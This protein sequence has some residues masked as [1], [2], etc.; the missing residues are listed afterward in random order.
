VV[1]G[2]NFKN[3]KD[4]GDPVE[5][6]TVYEGQGADELMLLDVSAPMKDA[7]LPWMLLAGWRL[8]SRFPLGWVEASGVWMILGRFS[9]PE[10]QRSVSTLPQCKTPSCCSLRATLL[11][12]SGLSLQLM[13]LLPPQHTQMQWT[14][15]AV[16]VAGGLCVHVEASNVHAWT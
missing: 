13:H 1:K 11:G 7:G 9:M 12:L 2:V 6:A 14:A 3:L 8:P 10:R 4:A 15:T 16:A 5:L